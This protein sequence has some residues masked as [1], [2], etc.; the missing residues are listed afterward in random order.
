MLFDNMR[1]SL[2]VL[3]VTTQPDFVFT[4]LDP[5]GRSWAAPLAS[6]K[7]LT[8]GGVQYMQNYQYSTGWARHKT[9]LGGVI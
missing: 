8:A 4:T 9:R 6:H 5:T 2:F 7:R 1:D 3:Q